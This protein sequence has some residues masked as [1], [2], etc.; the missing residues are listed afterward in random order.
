MN[1]TLEDL[2]G[3]GHTDAVQISSLQG[4]KFTQVST[5]SRTIKPGALF[6]ALRGTKIDGHA[7]VR[8][9]Y[10]KGALCAVVDD[11]SPR[12]G[13]QNRPAVIVQDTTRA[14]GELAHRYRMKFSIPFIAI[15]GSNGKTTTKEMI[16]TVLR[17][18]YSVHQTQGNLNNHIGVPAT[19]FGVKPRH[20]LAVVEIGTNHFGEVKY[21]SNIV[22]PTHALVTT[23]EHEHL[24]FFGSLNGVEHEEGDL[25]R[26]LDSRGTAF[27]NGDDRRIVR[28]AKGVRSTVRYGFSSRGSVRG[29][30]RGFDGAGAAL[31]GV[32]ARGKKGF[33]VQLSVPGRHNALNA[34]MAAV[35]GF[36]FNV[37]IRDIQNALRS[38]RPVDKRMEIHRIGGIVILNDTYNAN[39]DSTIRALQTVQEIKTPG[40][41]IV[42]LGDMLEL[43]R[44]SESEHR[45]VGTAVARLGFE[46]LLTF[47]DLART[48]NESAGKIT[49]NLHFD[50]KNSLAEYA[51]EL[52]ARGDV[53]LVKGS[54]GTKME[55]VVTFLIERKRGKSL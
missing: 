34:L 4:E 38:F 19:L 9:A 11:Q 44:A 27:V 10:A 48:I 43:G 55:D 30:I 39:A 2:L 29:T 53:L 15:A 23:I 49:V 17:K 1:V 16:G 45:K 32:A 22:H 46:Y 37:P 21:L 35:V 33:D 6:V 12:D 5:D 50:Q 40:K 7:F 26:S 41:K 3:I 36:S 51:L 20:D 14:L 42:I 52:A 8:E 31:L 54:R 28:Q 24:E 18:R 47:G 13:F 25:F